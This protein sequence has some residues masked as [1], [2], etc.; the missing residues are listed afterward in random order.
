MIN[1]TFYKVGKFRFPTLKLSREEIQK[2]YLE[3][4]FGIISWN[5][6]G[7]TVRHKADAPPPL[8][9]GENAFV[10]VAVKLH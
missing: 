7:Q 4:G 8:A 5:E 3:A 2:T 1:E 6:M 9:D 10:M